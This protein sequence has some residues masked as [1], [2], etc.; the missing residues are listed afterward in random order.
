MSRVR[1]GVKSAGIDIVERSAWQML[2]LCQI[3]ARPVTIS[4]ATQAKGM[5]KL[6]KLVESA[7]PG[8]RLEKM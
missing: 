2:P 6:R 7:Y 4:V 3:F 5:G 1:T 8:V